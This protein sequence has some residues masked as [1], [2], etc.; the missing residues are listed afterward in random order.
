MNP[1]LLRLLDNG[2]LIH[3]HR[4][5]DRRYLACARRPSQ[6]L[7][8]VLAHIRVDVDGTLTVDD[9][10]IQNQRATGDTP[11]EALANLAD[12]VFGLVGQD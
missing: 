3:L 6:S 12:N 5:V 1:S 11:G 9:D 4:Q 2:W 10:G 7:S 8:S